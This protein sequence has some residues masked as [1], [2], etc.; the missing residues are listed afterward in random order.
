MLFAHSRLHLSCTLSFKPVRTL[1]LTL[2]K[3]RK[4]SHQ[5]IP[6]RNPPPPSLISVHHFH[7]PFTL[8]QLFLCSST[9]PSAVMSAAARPK[10]SSHQT[11]IFH[12][13]V[14]SSHMAQLSLCFPQ[15]P[16]CYLFLFLISYELNCILLFCLLL[17][18]LQLESTFG[19]QRFIYIN[20][21]K[22]LEKH[23]NTEKQTLRHNGIFCWDGEGPSE[24]SAPVKSIKRGLINLRMILNSFLGILFRGFVLV[25][26]CPPLFL[27]VSSSC[28]FFVRFFPLANLMSQNTQITPF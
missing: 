7:S 16:W 10:S 14:H 3:G 25:T 21:K 6:C 15:V 27:I 24:Q 8:V 22:R 1:K 28:L 5:S 4:W 12:F 18:K 19:T 26:Q 9:L 2:P 23:I 17:L 20:L 13:F 11:K